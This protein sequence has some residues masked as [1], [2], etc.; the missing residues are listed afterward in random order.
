MRHSI[1]GRF[2]LV[3]IGLAIGPQLVVGLILAWQSY[4]SQQQQALALQQETAMRVT[5]QVTA[6][7]QE[8]ENE[9]RLTSKTQGLGKPDQNPSGALSDLLAYQPAFTELHL[10]NSKGEEQTAVYHTGAPSTGPV[11]RLKADEFVIPFTTGEV[12][13]GPVRF[14]PSYQ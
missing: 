5:G 3:F 13:F 11:N 8:L 6:F 1:R 10:F 12:Y 2:F 14:E 7:F 9:L 4:T